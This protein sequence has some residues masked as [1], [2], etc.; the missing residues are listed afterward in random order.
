MARIKDESQSSNM[1]Y[2]VRLARMKDDPQTNMAFVASVRRHPVLYDYTLPGHSSREHQDE[3][4]QRVALECNDSVGNC[5]ERWKNLRASLCRHLR[6]Q[7]AAGQ[8]QRPKKP[9]YL[10]E[11]MEFVVPFTKTRPATMGSINNAM[12]DSGFDPMDYIDEVKQ[13]VDDEDGSSQQRGETSVEGS[14]SVDDD[15]IVQNSLGSSWAD[16]GDGPAVLQ[17]LDGPL[18]TSSKKRKLLA[19]RADTLESYADEADLNFLKSLL[20]D[21]ALMT[22]RQKNS[23]KM[24]VLTA[25]E[26][27]VYNS[28]SDGEGERR[29]QPQATQSGAS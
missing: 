3:A 23:F 25:I 6:Q 21:M 24:A 5:K 7:Q 27:I 8:G 10:A 14:L 11:H 4:W 22:A 28:P 26:K 16:H 18:T 17:V 12:V 29:G 9:Y 2:S 1:S 15:V 20:P 13:E 19:T